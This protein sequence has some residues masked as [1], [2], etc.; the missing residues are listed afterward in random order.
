MYSGSTSAINCV[1]SVRHAG[2]VYSAVVLGAC[3]DGKLRVWD[4]ASPNTPTVLDTHA[5]SINFMAYED[6]CLLEGA[7]A[8]LILV[9]GDASGGVCLRYVFG[10]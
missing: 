5:S 9:T 8:V 10:I 3:A 6:A 7:S 2:N 4:S 1:Y